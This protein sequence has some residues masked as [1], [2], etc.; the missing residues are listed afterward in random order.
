LYQ[1]VRAERNLYAKNLVFIEGK[2]DFLTAKPGN[3]K[4]RLRNLANG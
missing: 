2:R 3:R 1:A 4:T